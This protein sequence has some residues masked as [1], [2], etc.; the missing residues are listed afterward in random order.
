[1]VGMRPCGMIFLLAELFKSES[2][3]QVYANLHEFLRKHPCVSN[4]IGKSSKNQ[5]HDLHG[6]SSMHFFVYI[7][8]LPGSTLRRSC[9][10]CVI[11]S[12]TPLVFSLQSMFVTMM[13]VMMMDV[14][15]YVLY[16][17][18]YYVI[19][20]LLCQY[21]TYYDVMMMD[22]IYYV[23]DVIYSYCTVTCKIRNSHWQDAHGRAYR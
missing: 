6:G 17:Y 10:H 3:S 2:K 20:S 22:V 15:Y 11:T 7:Y 18:Y 8:C 4:N 12:I 21:V 14:I 19:M 13:D 23:M 5:L 1:M 9:I 16:Y